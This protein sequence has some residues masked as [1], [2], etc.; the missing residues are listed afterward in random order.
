MAG[1][2]TLSNAGTLPGSLHPDEQGDSDEAMVGN[3]KIVY[4]V[5]LVSNL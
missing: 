4:F 5:S 2:A 3:D 1:G